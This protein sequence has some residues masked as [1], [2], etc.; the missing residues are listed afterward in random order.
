MYQ[1]WLEG[2]PL[3]VPGCHYHNA[4]QL[5]AAEKYY[6][7]QGDKE[8]AEH[9]KNAYLLEEKLGREKE[10]QTIVDKILKKVRSC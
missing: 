9:F 6:E 5:K 8:S 4:Q 10:N 7:K 2:V 1:E 3:L